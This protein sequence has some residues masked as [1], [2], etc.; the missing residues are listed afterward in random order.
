VGRLI[1]AVLGVAGGVL[2]FAALAAPWEPIANVLFPG[3]ERF[4]SGSS[5]AADYEDYA[6]RATSMIFVGVPLSLF[7]L[8]VGCELWDTSRAATRMRRSRAQARVRRANGPDHG[9]TLYALIMGFGVSLL[10]L[11]ILRPVPESVAAAV[12][13]GGETIVPYLVLGGFGGAVIA[14]PVWAHNNA[15]FRRE[16]RGAPPAP[17]LSAKLV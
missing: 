17:P 11:G 7:I 14:A 16:R 8:W 15:R 13:P 5:G 1:L 2:V 3:A 6:S 9:S 12:L 4:A 10:V